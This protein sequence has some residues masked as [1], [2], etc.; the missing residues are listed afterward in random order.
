MTIQGDPFPVPLDPTQTTTVNKNL[1]TERITHE[2][3]FLKSCFCGPV[4]HCY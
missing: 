1:L 2:F 4:H 3:D